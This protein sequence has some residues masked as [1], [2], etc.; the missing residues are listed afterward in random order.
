MSVH[1]SMSACGCTCACASECVSISVSEG[2][3]MGGWACM[4]LRNIS[5][6]FLII[7]SVLG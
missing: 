3:G 4:L 1:E 5:C 2:V 7:I 6:E